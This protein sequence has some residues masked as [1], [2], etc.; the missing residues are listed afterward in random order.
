MSGKH[1]WLACELDLHD[2]PHS[3]TPVHL[4]LGT[5]SVRQKEAEEILSRSKPG[6]SFTSLAVEINGAEKAFCRISMASTL[7]YSATR[8][9]ACVLFLVTQSV[10]NMLKKL[11]SSAVF[12]LPS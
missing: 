9:P 7:S 5:D 2:H 3:R 11:D 10:N 12:L 1:Q 4:K 6:E 8:A